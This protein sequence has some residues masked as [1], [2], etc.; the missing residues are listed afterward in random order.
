VGVGARQSPEAIG[1]LAVGLDGHV[2]VSERNEV[3][4]CLHLRG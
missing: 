4:L 3:L 2:R 1:E